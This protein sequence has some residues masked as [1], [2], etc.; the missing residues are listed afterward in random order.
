MTANRHYGMQKCPCCGYEPPRKCSDCGQVKPALKFHSN[1]KGRRK[2]ICAMCYSKRRAQ[3]EAAMVGSVDLSAVRAQLESRFGQ[4]GDGGS[5]GVPER[6]L[7]VRG[8][9][10]GVA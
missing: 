4:Y 3:R 6:E 1:G 2:P 10:G 7:A 5:S 9:R 8:V